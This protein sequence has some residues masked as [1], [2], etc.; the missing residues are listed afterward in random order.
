MKKIVFR[1]LLVLL[2]SLGL[3]SPAWSADS[4][5]LERRIDSLADELDSMKVD[6]MSR[7]IG[8]VDV[9]SRTSVFGYGEMHIN[10]QSDGPTRIDNHRYVIGVHSELAS[11]IHL[12]AEVDFEHGAQE[13]DFEFGYLDILLNDSANVR[14]GVMPLPVGNLNEYHEP[15]LFWSVE[16]PEFQTKIIPSSWNA[17]GIGLFGTPTEGINYRVFV[18]NSLQSLPGSG[19]AGDGI[20]NGGRT[21]FFRGTDGIRKGRV[22]L[23]TAVAADFAVVGRAEFSKLYPGL[24]LGFS[25]YNGNTTQGLINEDGNTTILEADMK[26]RNGWFDMNAAIANIDIQDAAAMNTFCATNA[27]CT[28][29]IADNIFGWNFQAGVHLFQLMGKSTTQDLI[30]F[31]LYEKIRPQDRMPSGTA[32]KTVTGT[33][34]NF[35]VVTVGMSYLPV[36]NVALKADFSVLNFEQT[37]GTTEKFN[38]GVAYMY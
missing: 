31:V 6:K 15:I 24:Q 3:A 1:G 33:S 4:K 5:E 8:R 36:A 30:P 25:F 20:G 29:D 38:L 14:A 28:N 21:G 13:I 27:G 12:N 23:N 17:G 7:R 32:P 26:Y 16:R 10:G 19:D 22:S 34:V 35:D 18:V 11:W 2:V 37:A 9:Q